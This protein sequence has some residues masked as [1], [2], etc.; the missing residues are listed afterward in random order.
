[1]SFL[2]ASAP[3]PLR[4]SSCRVIAVQ[5]PHERRI[6]RSGWYL[7]EYFWQPPDRAT[8]AALA[9]L[10]LR[11]ATHAARRIEISG[12]ENVVLR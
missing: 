10:S 2:C 12:S 9:S 8:T 3:H 6:E 5:R 7:P 1:M 4:Q 11:A